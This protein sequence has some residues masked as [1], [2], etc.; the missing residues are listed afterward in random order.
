ME[1]AKRLAK[2][3]PT[4]NLLALC[5]ASYTVVTGFAVIMPFFPIFANDILSEI[6]LLGFTVGIALQIGLITSSFMLTRFILAPSFGDLSDS[7]GRKP[8]ILVGMSLYGFLMIGFGLAYDFLTLII[9]RGLQGVASAAVW[10][11]GEA[12]IVDTSEKGKTGRNLGYYMM[13]MQAG[14]ATGPFLGFGFYFVL[15]KVFVLPELLSYRLTFVC[16]GLFGFLATLIVV[17]FVTDP[18][19]ADENIPV[20]ILYSTAFKAMGNKMLQ[21]PSFLARIFKTGGNYRTRSLYTIYVVAVINGFGFAMIFPIVALFLE[22]YYLLDPGAI[23][24][25]VGIVGVLALSGAPT[26]GFLS[27]KIGRKTTVW[28]SGIVG[29]VTMMLIG[30]EMGLVM[31]LIL[32]ALQRF[33]FAIM[34]PSFRA[35]QSDLTPVPVRGREFGIVQAAYNL[36]SV[37]GPIVGGYLY[38]VFF[39]VFFNLGNG[40]TFLGAGVTF[41]FAGFIAIFGGIL[42]LVLVNQK[43]V[44][45]DDY[46]LVVLEP[47]IPLKPSG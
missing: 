29:G 12:L 31:L 7:T 18:K 30:M 5:M 32:F 43:S 37:L 17:F 6:N 40:L 44:L 42:I 14:M 46:A 1:P 27:D 24:L 16:V 35:L 38:D 20:K 3:N 19:T 22:D 13:S 15:N 21:S 34:Q 33:L 4:M 45:V 11:V 23:A 26:G 36:G 9:V 2:F 25:A 47:T 10:P 39:D 8:V 28:L 41:G